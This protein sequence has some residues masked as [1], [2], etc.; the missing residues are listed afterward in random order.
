M[1]SK[2]NKTAERDSAG[3]EMVR[4]FKQNPLVFI[5]TL[6][7]LIIVVIAFVL[8]PAIV[9][10]YGMGRNV[11]LTFGYYDKAP[12]SYVPGNYF[13]QYYDMV[14]RY[15]Q[16]SVDPENYSFMGYQIWRESFEAA[17][18]HTAMLQE[19][20]TAGY[21][22]PAKVV[23]R[24]VAKLPQ[25][26][27]NGRFSAALYRQMDDNR[28][29]NLWRQVQ[30]DITKN[31]FRSDVTGLLI[32]DAEASFIG[33]MAATERSFEM[34][35]FP[36]DAFPEE[37]YEAY[38]EENTDLFKSVYLSMITVSSNEREA[39][40]ILA[41]IKNGETTFEDAA[42]AH[43]ADSYAER[44]GDMGIKMAHELIIDIPEEDVREA[45]MALAKGEYSNVIKTSAGWSFFRAE[46]TVREADVSDPA[47]LEKVRSYMRN[48]HGGRMENWAIDQAN[49]F[50]AL[51]D[52]MG[53]ADAL[54]Q[55]ELESRS[56]GPIPINYGSV[57]LFTSLASQ[58]VSELSGSAAD[59]NFWKVA[60]ST[61]VNTPSEP[62]VQGGNVLVLFPT[63]E[64]EAEETN[65]ERIAFMYSSY[66]VG[67]IT[68][69]SL[70]QHFLNSPKM[71]DKFFDVYIRYF[72]GE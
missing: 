56:F 33:K 60:F 2:D 47:V 44:G 58:S 55:Q 9:P 34:V 41:S 32:P 39:Q 20:K 51:V 21:E 25:F 38:L 37:G 62:V 53:F 65:I 66:W 43:S 3:S 36:V 71:E 46:D 57:E 30:E 10:E 17:V 27:E 45:A 72:M 49:D 52:E 31:H 19:M 68:E 23:D 5:G 59:E 8:V 28:R 26:Q 50:R 4:R 13:A 6:V 35:V 69:Q 24:D 18:V 16:N 63:A 7:I 48:F 12:I 64:T 15:R 22:A 14:A 54:A 42:R 70:L 1:A 61:P 29:L 67:N 40:R 11:D